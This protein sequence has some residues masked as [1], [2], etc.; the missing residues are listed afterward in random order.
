MPHIQL[1]S[2]DLCAP[3]AFSVS[4]FTVQVPTCLLTAGARYALAPPTAFQNKSEQEARARAAHSRAIAGQ[5][6]QGSPRAAPSRARLPRPHTGS[7]GSGSGPGVLE[8]VRPLWPADGPAPGRGGGGL[9]SRRT[10]DRRRNEGRYLLMKRNQRFWSGRRVLGARAG[11]GRGGVRGGLSLGG[12]RG[13]PQGLRAC[14]LGAGGHPHAVVRTQDKERAFEEKESDLQ[15]GRA[16]AADSPVPARPHAG[17]PAPERQGRPWPGVPALLTPARG[18]SLSLRPSGPQCPC[19][20]GLLGPHWEP[21]HTGNPSPPL[22][23]GRGGT[24]GLA[25]C[26]PLTRPC[27]GATSALEAGARVR[28]PGRWC[29]G[30]NPSSVISW[31]PD[32]VFPANDR[33][34]ALRG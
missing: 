18:A 16:Q 23:P 22:Q 30:R 6:C 21:G 32:Q 8:P 20:R 14:T 7:S 15:C 24:G 10:G 5:P 2:R 26:L 4:V 29:A 11:A 25:F 13:S 28:A 3:Q 1:P 12:L 9:M 19:L 27:N 17:S 31:G 33:A 34:W